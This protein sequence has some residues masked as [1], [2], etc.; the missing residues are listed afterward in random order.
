[1][2]M[3]VVL[4]R[5]EVPEVILNNLYQQTQLQTVFGINMV[6]LDDGQPKILNLWDL[7]DDLLE[8]SR[9]TTGKLELRKEK[10]DISELYRGWRDQWQ[11]HQIA[12]PPMMPTA[13]MRARR[14]GSC[15]T[16]RAAG[17]CGH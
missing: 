2:R 17:A 15:P 7:I 8:V 14:C 11:P 5:G 4:K 3:V 1:M 12:T 10:V 16:P 13:P 6:A 9:I